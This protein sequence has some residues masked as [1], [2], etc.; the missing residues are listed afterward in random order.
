MWISYEIENGKKNLSRITVAQ[1]T[2]YITRNK[3]NLQ[4]AWLQDN[5]SI[6]NRVEYYYIYNQKKLR[7]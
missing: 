4:Q 3:Y 6:I 7:D 2:T 5:L 1:I